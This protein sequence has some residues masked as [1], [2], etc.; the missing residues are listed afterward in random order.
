MLILH[1]V[2][3]ISSTKSQPLPLNAV[4]F[5]GLATFAI[6]RAFSFKAKKVSKVPRIN[7]I[8]TADLP[9]VVL[10]SRNTAA[11]LTYKSEAKQSKD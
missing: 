11:K 5:S 10:T 2:I 9:L 1:K 8:S 3:I 6:L 7:M 4:R